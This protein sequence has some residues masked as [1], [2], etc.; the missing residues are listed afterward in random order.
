MADLQE[1]FNKAKRAILDREFSRMNP[2]QRQAVFHTEGPVLILAGAGSGKTT[3]LVN[4]T[5]NLIKY[6]NAYES[7][8]LPYGVTEEDVAF[9]EEAAESSAFDEQ[10]A[11][12]LM[13]VYPSKP[14]QIMAITFTN[15]AAGELKDRLT[16]MLGEEGG[17]VWASTFHA[18]CARML[19]RDADRL[20][21][22]SRFTIY[23]TDDSK[24]MIKD[25]MVTVGVDDKVLSH[26]VILGEISRAK[27]Q[28]MDA[29]AYAERVGSDFRLQKV[30]EVYEAYEKRL[31]ESDAMDFDDLL[32][33]TVRLLDENEDVLE[34]YRH[35]FRYIMID[36]YQ[37][38]NHAQY[39][40]VRMLAD[41]HRNL[42]VVGDDDQSIYKFRGATIENILSFENQY[43]DAQVIRLEQ[44]YRSTQNILDAA[45]AVIAN[46]TERKEKSLW[47]DKG[48]G[49]KVTLFTADSDR[50][51][52]KYIADTINDD[53]SKGR[54][55]SDHA[56]LYRTNAQSNSIENFLSRAG[57]PYRIIGGQ[58]FYERKEI[59]DL[60]AYLC[61]IN[62]PSDEVR[63][64]RIINEPKRGIGDRSVDNAADIAAQLSIPLFDVLAS[65]DQFQALN[66]S[67]S[68]MMQ[69]AQL[70]TELSDAAGD[71]TVGLGELFDMMV[72]K[73]DYLSTLNGDEKKQDRLE[74]IQELKTNLVKY[75]DEHGEE[76][77][78][79]DF[80]EEVALITDI[81][82]YDSAADAVVMMTL[83]SAKGLEFPIVFIPG[84]EE[85]LFPGRQSAYDPEEVEEERRLAYVGITR[86]KEKLHLIH[87]RSR[88]IYGT[89]TRNMISRFAEE[90]PPHII[91]EKQNELPVHEHHAVSSRNDDSRA[92][93]ASATTIS[94]VSKPKAASSEGFAA[95][96]R[97]RHKVFGEGTVLSASPLGSDTLLAVRF[98]KV[99]EKKLMA[100]FAGLKKTE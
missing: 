26:K 43:P 100:N 98:D 23:D 8:K 39:L 12:K 17:E 25:I 37:D 10:R 90:I 74:N 89:T 97:V 88:M 29:Q 75:Q 67:A 30:A 72:E 58:R 31:K 20:G 86:A 35:R 16:L 68:K 95:G 36:E 40:F 51:E 7:E 96:D 83:H 76:T 70:I 47:T 32:F 78:L 9:L 27:E 85:G 84:M 33:N 11:Q 49:D 44:N 77:E 80:L 64:R 57:V 55:F 1:R 59:K 42:C 69:F 66:R 65:A 46:N 79:G 71:V 5:A 94:G 92:R 41:G 4:R 52:A 56:V 14:W 61:V 45:N 24:R 87:A 91:E 53:V 82:N 50:E 38:T 6:G 73:T 21:F 62:N 34:Y 18:T 15:K 2:M 81:D 13:A 63:L 54:K 3:V 99:G 48:A 60:L 28:M 22:T 93:I 19:R